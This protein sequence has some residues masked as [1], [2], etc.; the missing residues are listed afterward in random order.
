MSDFWRF[1]A[2]FFGNNFQFVIYVYCW[3]V[4]Y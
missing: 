3:L 4:V 1:Y 2:Y